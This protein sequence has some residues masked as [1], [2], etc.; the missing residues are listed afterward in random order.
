MELADSGI[1]TERSSNRIAAVGTTFRQKTF[2]G[3]L[4]LRIFTSL[5]SLVGQALNETRAYPII[6]P[7]TI[8][9]FGYRSLYN[10]NVLVILSR[11]IPQSDTLIHNWG[12]SPR[13]IYVPDDLVSEYQQRY[14]YGTYNKNY[15]KGLS[16]CPYDL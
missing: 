16:E 2:T 13:T 3:R 12:S 14:P 6:I 4:D 7:E 1:I 8:T 10:P 9:S 15:F 5:T 11:T